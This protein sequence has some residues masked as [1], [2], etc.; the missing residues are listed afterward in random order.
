MNVFFD[1]E[2]VE[3]V[4]GFD[5]SSNKS[6]PYIIRQ[7][8]PDSCKWCGNP[9]AHNECSNLIPLDYKRFK[10]LIK[11]SE[12]DNLWKLHAYESIPA[13]A[14]IC[15]FTGTLLLKIEAQ[16]AQ[17]KE[18]QF[19]DLIVPPTMK[20]DVQKLEEDGSEAMEFS[21]VEDYKKDIWPLR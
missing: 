13:G 4:V 5:T 10:L 18:G 15:F 16:K 9:R 17:K 14:L 2:Q 7:C 3:P 20:R 19:F 21:G 8:T 6:I 12:K 1:D 11:Y